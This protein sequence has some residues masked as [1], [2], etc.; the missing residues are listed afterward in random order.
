MVQADLKKKENID[1]D[2]ESDT[3][4]VSGASLLNRRFSIDVRNTVAQKRSFRLD[5]ENEKKKVPSRGGVK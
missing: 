5:E 4:R 3:C 2:I 1:Y